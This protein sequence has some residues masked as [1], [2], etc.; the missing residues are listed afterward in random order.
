MKGILKDILIEI[1]KEVVREF[2]SSKK[3]SKCSCPRRRV[4]K[5]V[6]KSTKKR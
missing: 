3:E 2:V 1:G 4:S 6:T 5:R